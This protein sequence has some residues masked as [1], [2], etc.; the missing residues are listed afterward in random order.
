MRDQDELIGEQ[1][2]RRDGGM[3]HMTMDRQVDLLAQQ[4]SKDLLRE[5]T[6]DGHPR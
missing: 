6:A 4:R 1:L 2:S 5:P 3:S